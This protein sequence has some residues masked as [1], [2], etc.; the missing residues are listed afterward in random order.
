MHALVI[1][2]GNRRPE[3]A[4][5][6][7]FSGSTKRFA[8]WKGS[9]TIF[10][11]MEEEKKLVAMVND[12]DDLTIINYKDY[13]DYFGPCGSQKLYD[14]PG[15]YSSLKQ[16]LEI[17]IS[18]KGD[19]GKEWQAIRADAAEVYSEMEKRGILVSGKRINPTYS[20]NVYSGRSKTTGFNIQGSN[21]DFEISH[22]NERLNIFVRFDWI[23]A[24]MRIAAYLSGDSVLDKCY[25]KSD[26][27][28]HI[29]ESLGGEVERDK[30]K[31][32]LNKAVN[33]LVHN[34]LIMKIFPALGGW[35]KKQQGNLERIG[36][37]ESILGR[38]F[39]TDHTITGNRRAFNGTLQGS[40]AHAMQ[41]TISKVRRECGDIILAEQ[42][43]SLTI[44]AQESRLLKT[45]KEVSD[46]MISPL[47][48]IRMP[49]VVEIGRNWGR[50]KKYKEFR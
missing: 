26:P 34:D 7:D 29:M 35:I 44:V 30:C 13:C 46:I 4:L 40:V 16:G 9:K 2:W 14:F 11:V 41:S 12:T 8:L 22:P 18:N 19:F 32:A 6:T 17:L 15:E 42:H 25:E 50:Y 39:Y 5:I 21:S 33:A 38:K 37:A 31:L 36:Y 23:A 43:D 1:K 48:G 20:M 28:T 49:L 3:E 47:D 24:D 27:Y 45:I 10:E